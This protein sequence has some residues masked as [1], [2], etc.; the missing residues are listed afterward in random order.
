MLLIDADTL[1]HILHY[2]PTSGVFTW[3]VNSGRSKPGKVAGYLNKG[4]VVIGYK[5]KSCLAHRLAFL[6]MTGK[7]P[8]LE[9]DHIDGCPS[10]NKWTN[11]REVSSKQNKENRYKANKNS[12]HGF[13]GV[14]KNH[15]NYMAHIYHNNKSIYLGTFGSP[16]EAHNKYLEAKRQLHLGNN[17]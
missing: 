2:D 12:K 15:K 9:V 4:Y 16:E 11:L 3:K 13:L 6:Y 7:Y 14:T 8:I 5:G 1:K 10:N 17:L